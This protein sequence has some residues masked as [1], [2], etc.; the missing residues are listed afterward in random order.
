LVGVKG[1]FEIT[2]TVIARE[3]ARTL[4][5]MAKLDE[6]KKKNEASIGGDPNKSKAYQEAKAFSEM[7]K[8]TLDNLKEETDDTIVKIGRQL[9]GLTKAKKAALTSATSTGVTGASRVTPL[10]DEERKKRAKE[11]LEAEKERLRILDAQSVAFHEQ[12]VFMEKM[13]KIKHDIDN[14]MVTADVGPLSMP[15]IGINYASKMSKAT[16]FA[17]QEASPFVPPKSDLEKMKEFMQSYS[18]IIAQGMS[19]VGSIFTAV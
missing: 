2:G 14:A 19:D 1:A 7:M 11:A 16:P 10:S 4:Y 18:G 5:F 3:S 15:S 13:L 17:T 9:D 12:I 6:F 8:G